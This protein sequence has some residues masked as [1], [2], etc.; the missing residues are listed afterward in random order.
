[1]SD[2]RPGTA[3]SDINVYR[4]D[5]IGPTGPIK[6]S[7]AVNQIVL[8]FSTCSPSSWWPF[9]AGWKNRYSKAIRVLGHTYFSHVDFVI[10]IELVADWGIGS[11]H[12]LSFI[13]GDYACL[14]ASDDPQSSVISGNPRGVAIRPA[15]YQS[16]GI[17]RRMI[18]Q[19]DRAAAILAWAKTQIGKPFDSG[20]LSPRVFLSDPYYG[21]VE[22]RNWRDPDKWFC[23]EYVTCMLEDGGYWGPGVKVP[24]KKNRVTPADLTMVLIM[25]P[26]L[27]NRNTWLDPVPEIAMGPYEI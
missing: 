17:R 27:Q 9:S 22:S 24:I 10:P 20:A 7:R 11:L 12:N 21:E 3:N 2:I 19:T 4:S 18:L 26:N 5:T 1:M 23:A 25:D 6:R 16:F 13:Y 8:Q 15:N 14:G